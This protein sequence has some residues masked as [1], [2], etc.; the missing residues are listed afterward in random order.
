MQEKS[1]LRVSALG[2]CAQSVSPSRSPVLMVFR[3]ASAPPGLKKVKQNNDP[4]TM[5]VTAK[6]PESKVN[7]YS[8]STEGEV[9][10]CSGG[11]PELRE[12]HNER[13]HFLG[14]LG[15]SVLERG[16]G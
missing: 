10:G 4:M 7:L 14:S 6:E 9:E 11:R 5:T 13:L 12:G 8:T 16:G 15:E 2:A 3:A 1:R